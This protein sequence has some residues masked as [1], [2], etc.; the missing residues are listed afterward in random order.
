MTYLTYS[1]KNT[2]VTALYQVLPPNTLKGLP[3]LADIPM[4]CLIKL[5]QDE[6]LLPPTVNPKQ[7]RE[8]EYKHI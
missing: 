7:W 8:V 1:N 3:P 5:G 2:L 6:G 4:P